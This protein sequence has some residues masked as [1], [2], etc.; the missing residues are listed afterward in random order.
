[1]NFLQSDPVTLSRAPWNFK[2]FFTGRSYDADTI[3]EEIEPAGGEEVIPTK[4]NRRHLVRHDRA[5]YKW[6]N[7]I[8]GLLNKRKNLRRMATR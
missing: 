5:E 7:L 6:R 3:R 8:N 2:T 4:V 1:M